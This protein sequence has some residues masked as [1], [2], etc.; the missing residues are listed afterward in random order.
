MKEKF[1]KKKAE[2]E[3]EVLNEIKCLAEIRDIRKLY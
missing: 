1:R 3:K 2:N